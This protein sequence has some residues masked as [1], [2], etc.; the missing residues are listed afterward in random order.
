MSSFSPTESD[1]DAMR[2][3]CCSV[4]CFLGRASVCVTVFAMERKP[5]V[6]K[7]SQF[8]YLYWKCYMCE[9]GWFNCEMPEWFP[10]TRLTGERSA[11]A[12]AL[13]SCHCSCLSAG[14]RAA[15][16]GRM[17]WCFCSLMQDA[18]SS[19]CTKILIC[20]NVIL[21]IYFHYRSSERVGCRDWIKW[22]IFHKSW[23]CDSLT[24]TAASLCLNMLLKSDAQDTKWFSIRQPW[25]EALCFLGVSLHPSVHPILVNTIAGKPWGNFFK[26]GTNIHLDTRMKQ[27]INF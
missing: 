18:H 25:P 20:H 4:V 6:P 5:K 8:M 17:S 21:Y 12:W 26:I 14:L 3:V 10:F 27:F 9:A 2:V 23:W 13:M 7:M 11:V 19:I 15:S 1:K 24:P 16:H 22:D